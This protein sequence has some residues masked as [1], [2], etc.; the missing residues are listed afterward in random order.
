MPGFQDA[1]GA[2]PTLAAEEEMDSQLVVDAL[3][4]AANAAEGIEEEPAASAGP[5]P[6]AKSSKA[7][8]AAKKKAAA[9]ASS[10]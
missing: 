5:P 7:K 9:A 2:A 4:E 1:N 8:S 6:T 10:S 3:C